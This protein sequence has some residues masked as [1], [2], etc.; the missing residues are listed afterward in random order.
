VAKPLGAVSKVDT[1]TLFYF[2]QQLHMDPGFMTVFDP[3]YRS[4]ENRYVGTAEASNYG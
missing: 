3:V 4:A 2:H 1:P